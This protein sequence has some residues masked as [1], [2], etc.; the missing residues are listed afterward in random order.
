MKNEIKNVEIGAMFPV[1][2][3]RN[4]KVGVM[5]KDNHY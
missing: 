5:K 2:N 3:K 4:K 1:F